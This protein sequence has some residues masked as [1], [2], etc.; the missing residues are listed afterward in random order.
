LELKA[1]SDIFQPAQ[2]RKEL[3]DFRDVNKTLEQ[4]LWT[5]TIKSLVDIN[6]NKIVI[7]NEKFYSINSEINI[8]SSNVEC[9]RFG[10]GMQP[11]LR[12]LCYY[13]SKHGTPVQR[14]FYTPQ[15]KKVSGNY[16][17]SIHIYIR[18]EADQALPIKSG[19][20]TAV[21]HFRDASRDF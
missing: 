17:D 19:R 5:P 11:L 2:L 21:L 10:S 16:L 15:Y 18:N 12:T 14:S 20:V 13:S 6:A 1:K 9:E 7:K 3:E 8:F 4:V